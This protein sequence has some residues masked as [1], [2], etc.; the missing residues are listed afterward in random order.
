LSGLETKLRSVFVA[1][2]DQGWWPLVA[3]TLIG[4]A[5]LAF[6]EI[7]DEVEDGETH[8]FDRAV[9]LFFRQAGD[10][11]RTIGPE[12]LEFVARDITALGGT[13]VLVL[14]TVAALGFMV[15]SRK[16]GAALFTFVSIVG[17]T[18]I[19]T[20]IKALVDRA[21]PDVVPHLVEVSSASF[22]SGHSMLS[23]TT[24]LTLGALL[25]EVQGKPRFRVYII[26]WALCV[27]L[28]VGWSRMFLGVH[29]PT[30]VLGGWCL[31]SAWA[32]MCGSVAYWLQRRGLIEGDS[33]AA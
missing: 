23:M 27:A 6:V 18:L 31:G 22:P 30:D 26:A 9:L 15:L 17:G 14:L 16:W 13:A 28:L 25:A 8:D 5:L 4:G 21:R 2:R 1:V 19:S 32:L 7:V 10:P 12:W 11:S 33:P 20:G 29:W 3:V 24:Y